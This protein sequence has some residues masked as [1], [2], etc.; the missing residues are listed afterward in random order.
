MS[1]TPESLKLNS[2]FRVQTLLLLRKSPK[3]GY[4]LAK[5][6]ENI[7]GKKPSSGKIY[8]FLHELK[9]SKYIVELEAEHAGGRSKSTYQLTNK[10]EELVDDLVNRMGNLLDAR[11]EQML[12]SCHHCGARLYE[13]GVLEKNSSGDDLRFCCEHCKDAYFNQ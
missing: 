6:L 4:D 13:S 10:G 1:T 2:M 12:E 3:S 11:L 9:N 5:E 8:P 7:M